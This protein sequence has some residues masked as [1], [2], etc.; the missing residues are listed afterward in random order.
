MKHQK[1][2][3]SLLINESPLLVLPSLAVKAGLNEAL[4]LQQVHYWI[5][6]PKAGIDHEGRRWV[7][8]TIKDWKEQF[9]FWSEKTISRAM[10]SAKQQGFLLC[11]KLSKDSW[12]K[13]MHYSI[14]YDALN[15]ENAPKSLIHS[16]GTDCPNRIGQIVPIERDRLSVSKGTDCPYL[17]STETSSETSSET[18]HKEKQNAAR[19][20]S[21]SVEQVVDLYHEVLPNLPSVLKVTDA[22]RKAISARIH[23]D[24]KTPSEWR[25]FFSRVGKSD[26]LTGKADNFRADLEW[27]C[28][29]S[30]FLKVLEGRYDPKNATSATTERSSGIN[31]PPPP[32]YLN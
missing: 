13:T 12:D 11:E 2:T 24:L 4:I 7:W 23:D 29:P 19:A 9:P 21:M 10:H 27:L 16:I 14:D 20:A 26:F 28:K 1:S 30:N 17:Y 15:S 32:R 31:N 6:N 18:T 8:N 3:S 5:S 22:R 25:V